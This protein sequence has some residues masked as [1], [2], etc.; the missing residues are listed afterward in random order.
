[1]SLLV[2]MKEDVV[3]CE[4]SPPG[5]V[6]PGCVKQCACISNVAGA[7]LRSARLK[8]HYRRPALSPLSFCLFLHSPSV[9]SSLARSNLSLSLSHFLTFTVHVPCVCVRA[10]VHALRCGFLLCAG[11][12]VT[13]DPPV[14]HQKVRQQHLSNN[15][16]LFICLKSFLELLCF[17]LG[18]LRTPPVSI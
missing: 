16:E 18:Q 17:G 11:T 14:T 8:S 7:D 4:S 13:A 3:A 15:G 1:M 6:S 10:R 2:D 5:R 12:K 9:S